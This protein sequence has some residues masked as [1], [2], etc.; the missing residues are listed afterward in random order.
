LAFKSISEP[1]FRLKD[2]NQ[3]AVDAATDPGGLTQKRQFATLSESARSAGVDRWYKEGGDYFVEWVREYYRTHSGEKI[4][5]DKCF[6]QDMAMVL[7]NPW[8]EE[9]WLEKS[10]QV[11][12][13]ELAIALMAFWL[14]EVRI[15]CAYGV[16]QASKLTDMIGP[17][18]QTAFGFCEPIQ[19]LKSDYRQFIGRQDIDT[20]QRQMTVGGT[21]ATFFYTGRMSEVKGSTGNERQATSS[22][23]SFVAH[24]IV[25]DEIELWSPKAIDV[26]KK[27]M[28]SVTMPTK[29]FRAGSTPGHRGGI[30][31]RAVEGSKYLF[32]WRVNCNHCHKDQFIFPYGNLLK[33]VK[34]ETDGK[35]EIAYLDRMGKPIDWFYHDDRTLE[36][37]TDTAYIGCQHCGKELVYENLTAG[38]FICRNT[39]VSAR[40]L[41]DS[42]IKERKPIYSAVAM[43]IPK[44][45]IPN[46]NAPERI[47]KL[48]TTRNIVDE[49]QQGLGIPVSIGGGKINLEI[50]LGCR[51]TPTP[52]PRDCEVLTVVGC[53]Q[54]KIAHVIVVQ[55]WILPLKGD[56]EERWSKAHVETLDYM[57][58]GEGF[59]GIHRIAVKYG[60]Q[61]VGLD[62]DPEVSLA[63]GYARAHPPHAEGG[64]YS[65]YLFD[66]VSLSGGQK[67]KRIEQVIQGVTVPIYRLHRTAGLDAVRDRIYDGLHK[68]DENMEYEPNNAG[69]LFH[70]YLISERLNNG[71]WTAPDSEP[72]HFFH[73]DNFAQMAVLAHLLEP[74]P[75]PLVFGALSNPMSSSGEV[76]KTSF[77]DYL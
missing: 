19:K 57:E 62:A 50:L 28:E 14:A 9:V 20:K 45:C 55:R 38:S 10:A 11:G 58:L 33:G 65:A 23:S 3:S 8:F 70:Q 61:V 39:G 69:S 21:I 42:T 49:L 71:Q 68:F 13:S 4:S 41:C 18:V 59:E 56:I 1:S 31:D 34:V 75:A 29:P 32:Q 35:V 53:D 7:G 74:R 16:E 77:A 48:R 17:R 15:P 2:P 52:D 72:D 27:R 26:A 24:A 67:F 6:F 73:A 36:T 76:L 64:D 30:V 5:W 43:R 44:L 46:F 54:G 51:F 63:G 66:Q 22:V 47:R 37:K 40:E 12:W 25:A 60:A